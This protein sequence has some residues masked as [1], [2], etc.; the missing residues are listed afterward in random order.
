MDNLE[1]RQKKGRVS[2]ELR[3]QTKRRL[4]TTTGVEERRER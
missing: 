2:N 4:W 3:A 1:G